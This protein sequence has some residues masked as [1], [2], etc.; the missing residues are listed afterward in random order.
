MV[1]DSSPAGFVGPMRRPG[2]VL[3]ILGTSTRPYDHLSLSLFLQEPSVQ[4]PL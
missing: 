3:A 4:V 2:S 1:L